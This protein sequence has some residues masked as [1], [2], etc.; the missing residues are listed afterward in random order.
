MNRFQK[1]RRL[2]ALVALTLSLSACGTDQAPQGTDNVQALGAPAQVPGNTAG[3]HDWRDEVIYF[4]LTDRFANGNPA[5]DNGA[6]RNQ[7]DRADTSNPLAWHGG[8][9]AGL[10]AKIEEG[11]FKRMGFT[12]IWVSPVVLQVPAISGPAS[13][14]NAGK[15]FAGYHGYWAE[16]FFKVDPH[17]GTMDEYKALIQTAHKNGLK[18]IQD[19]VVNHAGYGA[20]LTKTNPE[21]FHTEAECNASSNKDVFCPLAGLPDFKQELPD[22]TRYLNNFVA[23]WQQQTGI[24]GL[25]IDTMKHAPDAYWRQFFAAGGPGNPAKIW[26]VGEVFNGDPAVLARYM[27]DLGSPSVF[28]FAL[29]FAVK[30]HLSSAGGDLG[31]VAGVFAQD[32]AYS[33][34]TRLT[35]FIDNHDVRRFV[36]EV[37][38]RGGSQTEATERLDLALSLLYT[39]RGTPSVYQGTETAQA[40]L[41]DPYNYATGQTNR[42]DMNFAALAQGQTDE[43]LAALAAARQKYPALTRGC[44]RCCGSPTAARPSWL[45]AGW[46]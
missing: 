45:T 17:L 29:Y 38:E 31:R 20:T 39:S 6:D 43:R 2:G 1:T 30:D 41:G 23:Y 3:V 13:G 25:R 7:G 10:K 33:D 40:G 44:S 34:P 19:V 26:S 5:N 42:E 21:W 36:S 16:D 14:P 12:A 9:F 8:D 22:V 32:G 46:S 37:R 27:D 4:A 18:V 35:T 24:N 28:D 11:Y 15:L